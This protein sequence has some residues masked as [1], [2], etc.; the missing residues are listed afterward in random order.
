MLQSLLNNHLCE[1]PRPKVARWECIKPHMKSI[2]K[3]LMLELDH[4]RC[5]MFPKTKHIKAAI[6]D[7]FHVAED[8]F[9]KRNVFEIAWIEGLHRK[10]RTSII[11]KRGR[12][13]TYTQREL[14]HLLGV[15]KPENG[16]SQE[17]EA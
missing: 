11:N 16:T 17:I 6:L 10:V 13:S 14:W 9:P 15:P 2:S 7:A 5:M 3:K 1:A 8:D 4:V 12:F